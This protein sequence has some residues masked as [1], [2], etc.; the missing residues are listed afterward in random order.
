MVSYCQWLCSPWVLNWYKNCCLHSLLWHKNMGK[1]ALGCTILKW[2][3]KRK[4]GEQKV[5]LFW[6]SHRQWKTLWSLEVCSSTP[7]RRTDLELGAP[8]PSPPDVHAP[9]IQSQ[10]EGNTDERDSLKELSALHYPLDADGCTRHQQDKTWQTESNLHAD[11]KAK[12]CISMG[13]KYWNPIC[14][15]NFCKT[16]GHY[17]L[18]CLIMAKVIIMIIL[19][20]IEI[21]II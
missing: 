2:S 4:G 14:Y 6:T 1:Q 9:V 13:N 21:Q 15:I 20:N 10:R 5:Y 16:S 18:D 19:I 7:W 3:F 12:H 8:L 17:L 11:I